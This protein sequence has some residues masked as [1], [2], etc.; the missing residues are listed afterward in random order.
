MRLTATCVTYATARPV[1]L[2]IGCNQRS[3]RDGAGPLVKGSDHPV[4]KWS[5]SR[6]SGFRAEFHGEG[7][8]PSTLATD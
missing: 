5:F 7:I 6:F 2:R 3:S 1:L 4:E 8:I